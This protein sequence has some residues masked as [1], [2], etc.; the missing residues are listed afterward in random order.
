MTVLYFFAI[1]LYLLLCILLCS[2][3]LVQEGK[4][5]L[6]STFGGGEVS[7]S[8]FGTATADVLKK[9]T[10]WLAAVFLISCVTLSF[11]TEVMGRTQTSV[12]PPYEVEQPNE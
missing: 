9:F 4:G 6:G 12:P 5:G 3:I 1:T 2:V 10:G 8:L 11:W 7:D